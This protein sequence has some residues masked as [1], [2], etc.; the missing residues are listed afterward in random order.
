MGNPYSRVSN[1]MF[2]PGDIV[3]CLNAEHPPTHLRTGDTYTV[4]KCDDGI[5]EPFVCLKGKNR[6]GDAMDETVK[7]WSSRFALVTSAPEK[8]E[9][10]KTKFKIGDRVECVNATATV[11]LVKGEVYSVLN[12]DEWSVRVRPETEL[13]KMHDTNTSYSISRFELAKEEKPQTYQ[14]FVKGDK[15]KLIDPSNHGIFMGEDA[16][17]AV[18]T[19]TGYSGSEW[20]GNTPGFK[21]DNPVLGIEQNWG[22]G[23]NTSGDCFFRLATEKEKEMA[24][25]AT[26]E[27][28]QTT[29]EIDMTRNTP[30]T[31]EEARELRKRII[32]ETGIKE[33]RVRLR[34]RTWDNEGIFFAIEVYQGEDRNDKKDKPKNLYFP[35]TVAAYLIENTILD[36]VADSAVTGKTDKI[37]RYYFRDPRAGYGYVVQGNGYST[38]WTEEDI[39]AHGGI[40]TH[41]GRRYRL[42]RMQFVPFVEA[43]EPKTAVR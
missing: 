30:M 14:K 38:G 21:V 42:G 17:N 41:G 19:V 25:T 29:E 2:K 4:V 26:L 18:M 40:M 7:F 16:A 6:N 10:P 36:L 31:L 35:S 34:N 1:Q 22:N 15:V 20:I 12:C 39:K 9:E 8:K 43:E 11:T 37:V 5:Y 24:L 13:A 27:T 3:R 23:R 32:K 28:K 33:G